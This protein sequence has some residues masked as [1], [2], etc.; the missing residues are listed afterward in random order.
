MFGVKFK[1]TMSGTYHRPDDAAERAI[2]FTITAKGS[3]LSSRY[4]ARGTIDVEGIASGKPVEG[5]LI[6]A[7]ILQRMLRYELEFSGDDGQPYAFAGQK[8]LVLTDL[9]RTMTTLPGKIRD[10]YG[11]VVGEGV[12]RFDL[13][14]DLLKFLSSF[15]LA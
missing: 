7:P 13:Q 4:S 12:V 14:G 10:R 6:L 1:E 11:K 9:H 5:T 15:R 3:P 8:D 2:S